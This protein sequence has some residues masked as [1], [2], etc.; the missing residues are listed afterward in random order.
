MV[1][2]LFKKSTGLYA[3]LDISA[4]KITIA[5]V[6]REKEKYCLKNLVQE[7]FQEEIIKNGLVSNPEHLAEFLKK[8]FEKDFPDIKTVNIALSSH[9][10]FI[11]TV[12]FPDMPI[13][14]LKIIAPQEASKYVSFSINDLNVDFQIIE[15]AK[16]ENKLNVILC[17]LS[18]TAARSYIEPIQKAGL[19]IN[20]VD[21]AS[22][23]MIRTL[24]HAEMINNP[25]AVYVSVLIGYETTDISVVK[26][27]MPVFIHNIQTGKKNIL[28]SVI[29][30]MELTREEADRKLP[31]FALLLPGMEASGNPELNKASN[32]LRGIFSNIASEIQKAI[33]FY[34]SQNNG[35][36]E[37]E[38]IILG[39]NGAC[40]DNID[41]YIANKLKINTELCNSLNNIS[42]SN[43]KI[44]NFSIPALSTSIGLALKGF[45][46]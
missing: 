31:E 11:K 3:G 22:F 40:V 37:I 41:K 33:E 24:A 12:S 46:N 32:I 10:L 45:E 7:S 28:E 36:V 5:V 43:E 35:A 8:T 14:E 18:K 6:S 27:G 1:L 15:K 34:N 13:E 44:S 16:A 20:A 38:K 17:A 26:N 2:K 19:E 29:K 39:G 4:E 30:G 21:V 9:N 23:A 42:Y 25:D